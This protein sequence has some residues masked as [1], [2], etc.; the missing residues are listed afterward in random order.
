[1]N[2]PLESS[3]EHREATTQLRGDALPAG[4]VWLFAIASGLC[5]ANVYYAQPLLDL[6]AASLGIS[7][8]AVGSVVT[9]TQIGSALAL[10]LLV[11]LGDRLE[12][13]RL[14]LGQ[15]L[16]LVVALLWVASAQ[17]PWLLLL[18]MLA[19]GLLGT[20]MTQGLIA[21]AAS[22]AGDN[23]RGRVVGAAQAGVFIGLLMA[24]VVAGGV[25]DLGGWR[26]V[27]VVAALVMLLLAGVLYRRLPRLP[28]SAV[29]MRYPQLLGSMLQLLRQDRVLQIRGMLAL[30]MFAVFNIFWSALVLPLSAPPYGYSHTAIGAFGLV[31]VIGAL[32]A[33]GAGRWVDRGRGQA[34]TAM[35]LLVLLLAWWPLSLMPASL[36][37]LALGIVLLDLGG[38]ALHVSNQSLILREQPQ[39]HSRLVGLYMLFYAVGSGAG[40][41]ATTA[42]YARAGW[43]GVCV[44]G[45]ATCGVAGVF[46][47]V[48]RRYMPE[49]LR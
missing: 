17:S 31:G 28:A 33:T 6:L 7:L 34:V 24:R 13:R 8:A 3:L 32:G 1:M 41:I 19:V 42:T 4:L 29:T 25:A 47:L 21:Y 18:G 37:A 38:Q 46:W 49:Q 22:A 26:S 11:P 30:L 43:S 35:A 10:L 48:T 44:L 15:L 5:V 14:M 2:L 27:Y 45:A 40:A 16:A 12:R 9:A 23:E 36:W 20:A 39:A